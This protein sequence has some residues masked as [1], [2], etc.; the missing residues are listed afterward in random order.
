MEA[1]RHY[2]G[3]TKKRK[4]QENQLGPLLLSQPERREKSDQPYALR[5]FSREQHLL[6]GYTA[7]SPIMKNP[8]CE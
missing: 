5:T 4:T 3:A 2:I 1:T 7:P 6:P 8:V